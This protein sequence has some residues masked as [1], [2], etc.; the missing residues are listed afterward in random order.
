[1]GRIIK[2]SENT[3]L[4]DTSTA[5]SYELVEFCHQP[6][7]DVQMD[8]DPEDD[9]VSKARQIIQNAVTE[10]EIIINTTREE[11]KN[12]YSQATE[13]GYQAGLAQAQSEAL[14][15]KQQIDAQ[16]QQLVNRLESDIS[17]AAQDRIDMINSVEPA[18]LKLLLEM[19]EKV[20]KHEIKTNERV[21]IRNIRACLRRIKDV[22]EVT[23][24]VNPQEVE[25]VKSQREDLVSC[26]ECV[27]GVAIVDDR[28]IAAGG[29]L[30]ESTSGDFDARIDT[31]L[32]RIRTRI[33]ETAANAEH[34]DC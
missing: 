21:V 22:N 19:V 8:E 28:R 4:M 3:V 14:Q 26:S 6:P 34:T 23:I 32:E 27:H 16:T 7:A 12:L 11:T 2:A 17:Q 1:M 25:Y 30:V 13:E 24:R 9:A 20:V 10:A 18:L 15:H 5:C 33:M 29:C 31:Q